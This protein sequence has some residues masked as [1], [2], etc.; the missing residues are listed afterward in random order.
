MIYFIEIMRDHVT[1][2]FISTL[3][4]GH[5]LIF[6]CLVKVVIFALECYVKMPNP[7]FKNLYHFSGSSITIISNGYVKSLDVSSLLIVQIC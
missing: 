5:W 7:P 4:V 3:V 1:N 6:S 2:I